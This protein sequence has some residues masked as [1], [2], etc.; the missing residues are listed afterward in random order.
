MT[1]LI[2]AYIVECPNAK[3]A[4]HG[5]T[6][7]VCGLI[8]GLQRPQ[9]SKKSPKND[10]FFKYIFAIAVILSIHWIKLTIGTFM[11][12]CPKDKIIIHRA[13]GVGYGV[14]SELLMSQKIIKNYPKL[15]IFTYFGRISPIHWITWTNIVLCPNGKLTIFVM[16]HVIMMY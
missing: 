2:V 6:G 10:L 7:V 9:K 3:S 1:F 16:N 13:S 4:I 15:A 5:V 12:E 11:I 14:I 8:S